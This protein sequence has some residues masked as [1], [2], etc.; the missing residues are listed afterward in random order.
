MTAFLATAAITPGANPEAASQT[1]L[2]GAPIHRFG[3]QAMAALFEIL[4][5]HEDE[6]YARQAANQAFDL[7]EPPRG[8][9]EPVC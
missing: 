2:C 3:H 1:V 6:N 7:L 9:V 5:V 8:R 4:C